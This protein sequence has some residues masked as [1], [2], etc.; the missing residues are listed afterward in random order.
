MSEERASPEVG[1]SL[2]PSGRD[3]SRALLESCALLERP[4]RWPHLLRSE[5]TCAQGFLGGGMRFL[6]RLGGTTNA[7]WV[8]AAAIMSIAMLVL[9]CASARATANARRELAVCLERNCERE[10]AAQIELLLRWPAA[11]AWHAER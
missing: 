4:R 5:R 11:H 1:V 6:R 10:V 7:A 8:L 2:S 9:V 3:E